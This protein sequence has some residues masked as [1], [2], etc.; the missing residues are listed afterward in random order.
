VSRDE[1]ERL[2]DIQEAI[3]AIRRHL[4]QADGT[5]IVK[6]DHLLNDAPRRF[7]DRRPRFPGRTSP[8]FA[9]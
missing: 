3:G 5:P 9:T 1:Q 4:A 6:E 8:A 7:A 2:R